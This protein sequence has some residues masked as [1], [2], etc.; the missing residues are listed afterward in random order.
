MNNKIL[1]AIIVLIVGVL[2]WVIFSSD[3]TSENPDN[4]DGEVVESLHVYGLALDEAD[5]V[6]E[7]AFSL[8]CPACAQFHD[9]LKE[10]REEYKDKIAFRVR[11]FTLTSQFPNV[12]AAHRAAEAAALQGQFWEMHDLLFEKRDLW[13]ASSDSNPN[14]SNAVPQ[15]EVFAEEL[16]L[17]LEQFKIDFKSK[18][19]ND[20]VNADYKAMKERGVD[21][22][23]A[24]FINGE[25]IEKARL[26][27]MTIARQTLD[28]YLEDATKEE[29]ENNQEDAE[30]SEDEGEA[31]NKEEGS[32]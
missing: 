15:M 21:G 29:G 2:F 6:L 13:I 16:G 3:K 4:Q 20:I 8:S 30:S 1:I 19:V 25:E 12:L 7:E 24:F 32:E 23:P 9:L 22:T 27:N 28:E 10:L 18:K 11:H 5:V 31:E 14:P 17:D 26:G